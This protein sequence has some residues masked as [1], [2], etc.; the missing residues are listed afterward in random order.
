MRQYLVK[1][2]KPG[3]ILGQH[4]YSYFGGKR[5]LLLGSGIEISRQVITKLKQMGYKSIYI[6]EKG[7]EHIIPENLLADETRDMAMSAISLFYDDMREAVS[8]LTNKNQIPI[9]KMRDDQIRINP[10]SP[11][12]LKR[13]IHD[14]IHDIYLF[15]KNADYEPIIG[16]P[17]SNALHNHVLNVALIS[18]LIGG[19]YEFF[20]NELVELAM[21][22]ILHDVGKA[23]MPQIY[24]KQYWQLGVEEIALYKLHPVLGD[25][26]LN[27][28]RSF[29]EVER[30]MIMQHHERQDGNGFPMQLKGKNKPPIREKFILPNTIFRFAE[31]IAVADTFENLISGNFYKKWFSPA[32]A[33]A[34]LSRESGTGLN[35]SIVDTLYKVVTRF[36]VGSNVRIIRHPDSK[37][38]GY[39][40]VVAVPDSS[41]SGN[42]EVILIADSY[43]KPISPKPVSVDTSKNGKGELQFIY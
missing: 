36:P 9:H 5:T 43:L 18:I 42:V 7:T 16:I 17:Q 29:T 34:E 31:I 14:M 12:L 40:G 13:V 4:L 10:S 25:R 27:K 33:L 38:T 15:G 23:A 3:M 37:I 11:A 19:Q 2:L 35:S 39:Y 32:E 24:S 30:Q 28:S 1:K 21:G 8:H 20:E 22:A 26:L 6:S 41:K